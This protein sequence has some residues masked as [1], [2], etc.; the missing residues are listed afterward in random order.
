MHIFKVWDCRRVAK[1]FNIIHDDE[2]I[3]EKLLYEGNTCL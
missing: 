3:Y 2:N 1:E